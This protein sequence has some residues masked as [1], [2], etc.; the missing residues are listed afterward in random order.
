MNALELF[1][2]RLVLLEDAIYKLCALHSAQQ[3]TADEIGHGLAN[4]MQEL[5]KELEAA[6]AQPA[7]ILPPH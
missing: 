4:G 7:L 5:R 1:D 6:Q 2:R 3:A